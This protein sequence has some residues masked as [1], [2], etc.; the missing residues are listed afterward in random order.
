MKVSHKWLQTFFETPLP[1]AEVLVETSNFK[2]VEV[3]GTEEVE[4]DIIIDLKILADRGAYMLSHEGVAREFA[5][6]L[7]LKLKDRKIPRVTVMQ[8]VGP[9]AVS[10]PAV[11]SLVVPVV[12]IESD[13]CRR[14]TARRVEGVTVTE[15]PEWLKG[16]LAKLG[17]RSINTIVDLANF[18]MFDIGQPLHAFDADKVQ[19]PITIRLAREGETIETLDDRQVKLRPDNL[20]IA[21]N[22]GPIAIAGVKG[23]KR[24]GVTSETKNL[25]L[26]SANFNPSSVRKT[27]TGLSLRTDAS[28]RFENNLTADLCVEANENFSALIAEAIPSAKFSAITDVYPSREQEQ[29]VSVDPKRITER[30]G[31]EVGVAE[32]K[33]ILER[34]GLGVEESGGMFN[35]TIPTYRRDLNIPE[36]FA[37]E[38]G[39]IWGY[40]KLPETLPAPIKPAVN[41]EYYYT[42]KVRNILRDAGFSEVYLYSLVAQGELEVQLPLAEDKKCYRTNLKDGIDKAMRL[43]LN[44]KPLLSSGP[45]AIFEIGKVFNNGNEKLMLGWAV[46][47]LKAAQEKFKI[48][49]P[50]IGNVIPG[51]V[52]EL[53][54]SD[55]IE[56]LAEPESY[57][58][59][60]LELT[61]KPVSFLSFSQYP[62][63]LRDVAV[64]VPSTTKSEEVE[65]IIASEGG[66]WLMR[67]NLFD[68]FSKDDKTS[69]AFR[70][71]FQSMERTLTDQDANAVHARVVKALGAA[72]FTVR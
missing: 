40:D 12:K 35:L 67:I 51:M 25:I 17:Q 66:E 56:K 42:E 69:Y 8:E 27:S 22:M 3:E 7:D 4:G 43:N 14:Y 58:D 2:I 15:S 34:M 36:D 72:G 6:T 64:W 1:S 21:D 70:L 62:F 61:T 9:P 63:I 65:K 16:S 31:M 57:D 32:Q 11:K 28:K 13:L 30:L 47:D 45:L 49:A 38:I 26:E 18:V 52:G 55:A 24:A 5:A 53:D 59:L 60:N 23:G 48:L 29:K 71:V 33:K 68:T 19:G 46:T 50:I 41:K 39:R 37:E 54:L 10:P 44:N 20:V